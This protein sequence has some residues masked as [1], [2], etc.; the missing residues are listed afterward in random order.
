MFRSKCVR[1]GVLHDGV[2]LRV[3]CVRNRSVIGDIF[4]FRVVISVRRF[5]IEDII[6][7]FVYNVVNPGAA[8]IVLVTG[9][10]L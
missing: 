7:S 10:H 5:Y 2:L 1:S 8:S 9:N 6:L 3:G 4:P